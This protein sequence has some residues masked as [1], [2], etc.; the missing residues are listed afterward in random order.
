ME[1]T[2]KSANA[3]SV[4][5]DARL[6]RDGESTVMIFI[7]NAP[8]AITQKRMPKTFEKLVTIIEKANG[9]Q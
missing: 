3:P 6:M 4:K 2:K 8:V 7:G 1:E 5:V 9:G